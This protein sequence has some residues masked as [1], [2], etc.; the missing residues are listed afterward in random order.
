MAFCSKCG[1]QVPED[2]R[3]CP[4][5]GSVL[6][7]EERTAPAGVNTGD[8]KGQLADYFNTKAAD[9]TEQERQDANNVKNKI[10]A[11][12]AYAVA[13]A[14]ICCFM[15]TVSFL[16]TILQIIF[17][18]G[19]IIVPILVGKN[20]AFAR[21]HANNGLILT[22]LASALM[23]LQSI[24]WALFPLKFNSHFRLVH[25]APYYIFTIIYAACAIAILVLAIFGII[26]AAK[27]NK[28]ELPFIGGIKIIK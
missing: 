25:L 21:F 16:S 24:N 28:K 22:I 7:A 1:K 19:V 14:L 4:Y 23:I 3:F 17:I 15:G 20:S 8:A 2:T 11:I 12:L 27:G 10:M 9:K 6:K 18:G 5:C 13:I 26:H